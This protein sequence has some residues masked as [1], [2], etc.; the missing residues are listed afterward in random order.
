MSINQQ[1]D[2][3][4]TQ[5]INA[6][7]ANDSTL[8][9]SLLTMNANPS[10][11]NTEEDT[12][13]HIAIFMENSGIVR[14][15]LEGGSNPNIHDILGRT[16]LNLL[17]INYENSPDKAIMNNIARFL[18]KFGANVNEINDRGFAPLHMAILIGS[19][20]LVEILLSGGANQNVEDLDGNNSLIFAIYQGA[21]EIVKLLIKSGAK[22]VQGN[23]LK[24]PLDWARFYNMV[25][26][27]EILFPMPIIYRSSGVRSLPEKAFSYTF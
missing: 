14:L 27:V 6:T 12:A 20:E 9:A 7:F 21:N 23:F 25:D 11:Q 16:P 5:L 17:L 10:I 4:N 13:L 19:Q 8:V 26:I 1:D 2:E 15:L 22:N 24:T 3:G 18:V